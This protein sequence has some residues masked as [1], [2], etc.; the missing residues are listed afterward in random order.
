MTI[1]Y[2]H[3]I[4]N[5]YIFFTLSLNQFTENEH[6]KR[7]LINTFPRILV[8]ASPRDRLWGIGLGAKNEKAHSRL[9]WRGKNK[10]GFLLTHIR[11]EIMEEEGLFH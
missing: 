4:S 8:E 10:L 11:N 2:M 3:Y 7:E 9:T 6:F 1:E 5:V